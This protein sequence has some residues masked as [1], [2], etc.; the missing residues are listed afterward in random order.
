VPTLKANNKSFWCLRI[1][2]EDYYPQFPQK[3]YWVQKLNEDLNK[4][5]PKRLP[6]TEIQIYDLFKK[7]YGYKKAS[8]Y[9]VN[10]F[11]FQIFIIS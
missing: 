6:M 11:Y 5:K 8:K 10:K 2:L 9:K 4:L 7:N 1:D 3:P